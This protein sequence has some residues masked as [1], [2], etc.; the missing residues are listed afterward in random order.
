VWQ[1]AAAAW[2]EEPRVAD[3]DR[4]RMPVLVIWGDQDA[5]FPRE[6][7]DRLLAVLPH[8]AFKVYQDTGHAIHWERPDEFARDLAEFLHGAGQGA[9]Q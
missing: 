8:A 6:E 2:L 3:H 1:A 4:L 7:Q 5:V 9:A